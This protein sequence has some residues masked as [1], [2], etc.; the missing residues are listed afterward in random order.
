MINS[1]DTE[2]LSFGLHQDDFL[3]DILCV[4]EIM[5]WSDVTAIPNTPGYIKG[6]IN[7]RGLIVPIID[8][9]MR[10]NYTNYDYQATTVILVLK[11]SVDGQ[12]RVIGFVVDRVSDKINTL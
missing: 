7:L 5:V 12:E 1:S 6:V 11:L 8:L 3:I 9:R 2:Y 10:L 4:Q